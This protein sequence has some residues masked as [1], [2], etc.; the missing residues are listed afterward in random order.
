[1]DQILI[2][3]AEPVAVLILFALLSSVVMILRLNSPRKP[4]LDK[5]PLLGEELGSPEQRRKAFL[6]TAQDLYNKGYERFKD[7][8]WRLTGTDGERIVIP[9]CLLDDVKGMP[10][11]HISIEKAIEK[12]NEIK[13]TGLGGKPNETEFLIHLIRSD[14]THGLGRINERL[15]AEVTRT[16]IEELG[17]CNDWTEAVIYQKMLR[18]VAIASGNIFLGPEL[19]RSEDWIVPATMYTVDLFTAIGK[20]KQWSKW[21]RPIGQ[22]F[23]PEIKSL[24]QH[25]SN[26]VAWLSPIV[27]QRRRMVEQ[28]HELP[29][30]MLQWMMNKAAE[31]GV[32]DDSLALIQLNLGLAAIHTTTLT[33]TLVL[34]DIAV[35][36]ELVKEL[37][38]EIRS[39][40]AANGGKLTT[41]ALFEMKLLDSVMKESQRINPGNLVRFIRIV[42]KPITL[43]DGTHLPAGT[44][45]ESA[46][47]S[48]VQDSNLYSNPETFDGHRFMNLRAGA[49]P[50]PLGYK[51]REQH[52]FVT[53]TKEFMA[54]GYGRHACPGRFFAANEIKLILARI[55][56]EYEFEMPK[57][58]TERYP[59][60]NMGLDSLPDPTKALMFKRFS[61]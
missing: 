59:N 36:P 30:D 60:L 32:S 12:S 61:A 26:A 46:H 1:M 57:G 3:A 34:Y 6:S 28:G 55:L 29:D 14:L 51:N 43:S 54:F 10:D 16:V 39:V 47:A 17:P 48:I 2:L 33:T 41:H 15:E 25:R 37:R 11:S 45:I 22:Y 19:C 13:Y 27:A 52:Q 7:R 23:I 4:G 49:I 42:E 24:H 18:I 40:M 53:A 5:I 38:H 44:H 31:Y 21:T 8:V 20:L 56:L 58:F 9:R 35:Q 50:D